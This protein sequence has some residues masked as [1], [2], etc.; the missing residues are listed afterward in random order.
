MFDVTTHILVIDDEQEEFFLLKEIFDD[1]PPD[2]RD[3]YELEFAE[4]IPMAMEKIANGRWDLFIVDYRLGVDNGVD[5]VLKAQAAGVAVPALLVTGHDEIDLPEEAQL[6]MELGMLR[7]LHKSEMNWNTL[8][9]T[10]RDLVPQRLR[11]LVIDDDEDSL[12]ILRD[13]L[14]DVGLIQ[15]VVDQVHSL[16]EARVLLAKQDWD[17][18]ILDYLLRGEHGSELVTDITQMQTQ[19][20]LLISSGSEMAQKDEAFQLITAHGHAAFFPKSNFEQ[21]D[22]SK[23]LLGASRLARRVERRYRLHDAGQFSPAGAGAA[24]R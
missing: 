21:R 22:L 11:V 3:F 23:Y 15:F 7:F 10:I 13:N 1:L 20:F 17:I 24:R 2:T 6:Q 19:P 12:L 18:V 4:S 9:A 5:F 8:S 16:T 14:K